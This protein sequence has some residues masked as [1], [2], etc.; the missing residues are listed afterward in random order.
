MVMKQTKRQ[1]LDRSFTTVDLKKNLKKG[2][3]S[4][5][6]QENCTREL[7]VDSKLNSLS[8]NLPED[9]GDISSTFL[10]CIVLQTWQIFKCKKQR[11]VYKILHLEGQHM[12]GSSA[13]CRWVGLWSEPGVWQWLEDILLEIIETILQWTNIWCRQTVLDFLSK[14]NWPFITY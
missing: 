7:Y 9:E 3:E 12:C 14:Y 2:W 13:I 4:K 8:L 10:H 5:F 6:V 1:L 11:Q